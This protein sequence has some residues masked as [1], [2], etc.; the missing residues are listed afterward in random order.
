MNIISPKTP[1]K[2]Y[3]SPSTP[4]DIFATPKAVD[5]SDSSLYYSFVLS[6]DEIKETNKENNE[7]E[8]T[9]TN[10]TPEV[11]KTTASTPLLRMVLQPSCTPRNQMNKLV[12][13]NHLINPT[14]NL[15]NETANSFNLPHDKLNSEG[16]FNTGIFD[17]KE[18]SALNN[19][20]HDT[21]NA[22]S[23]TDD[24]EGEKHNT[25]IENPLPVSANKLPNSNGQELNGE[26]EHCEQDVSIQQCGS[27]R[28]IQVVSESKTTLENITVNQSQTRK[29]SMRP[30]NYTRRSS[31]YE[32][33]KVDPRKSLQVLKKV[34]N[35]VS[36][37][38][39]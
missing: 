7:I 36:G 33:R 29:K 21:D 20:Q 25:I 30:S 35:K 13:F 17:E 11:S 4:G 39:K 16:H 19:S 15:N 23:D 14:K 32:P 5:D 6:D 26:N 9:V 28:S 8:W 2:K 38:G 18:G 10:S 12:S 27:S 37:M 1:K 3:I 22:L 31:T 34:A 24:F